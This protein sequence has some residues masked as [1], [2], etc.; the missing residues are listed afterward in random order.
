VRVYL[1]PWQHWEQRTGV[2]FGVRCGIQGPHETTKE[3]GGFLFRRNKTV[4]EI[5]PYYPGMFIQL[6]CAKDSRHE[7]DHAVLIIRAGNDG[8][9]IIGPK[10]TQTGWWTFGMSLTPDSRCHFFAKPGVGD[11]TARDHLVSTTPYGRQAQYF[12]TIFFDVCSIDDGVTWSTPWIIDDPAI[13]YLG[14][15]QSTTAGGQ[16]SNYR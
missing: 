15:G 12:N 8:Q 2:S 13:Y 11:L 4:T 1:P 5:E 7:E 14:G 10:I 9:D 16:Y 3:V 6:N